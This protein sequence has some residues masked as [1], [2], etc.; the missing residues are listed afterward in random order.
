M[1]RQE[2]LVGGISFDGIA[3]RLHLPRGAAGG[4]IARFV[5]KK[6]VMRVA[7]RGEQ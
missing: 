4:D 6:V 3:Q 7:I 5:P 2:A 1:V